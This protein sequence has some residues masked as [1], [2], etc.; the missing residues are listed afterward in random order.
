[1]TAVWREGCV[2]LVMCCLMVCSG[3]GHV[4][5]QCLGLQILGMCVCDYRG[6]TLRVRNTC[7]TTMKDNK[8]DLYAAPCGPNTAP[9]GFS[10]NLTRTVAL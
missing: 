2:C 1:M 6:H 10:S 9:C 8:F 5:V 3:C 4:G 7:V